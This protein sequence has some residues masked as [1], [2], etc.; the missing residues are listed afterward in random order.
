M[1]LPVPKTG[2]IDPVAARMPPPPL[3]CAGAGAG[4]M[5]ERINVHHE[6]F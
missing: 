4:A 3:W 1:R 6:T 2:N 5:R